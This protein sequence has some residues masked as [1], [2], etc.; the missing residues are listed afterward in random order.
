MRTVFIVSSVLVATSL[1]AACGDDGAVTDADVAVADSVAG[2]DV[3]DVTDDADVADADDTSVPEDTTPARPRANR[4]IG[5][6]SMGAAA[7]TIALERPGTFDFVGALGGYADTTYMMSQMLRLQL[8]GF[9]PLTDLA[10]RP[11]ALDDPDA[12]PPV[13]CGPGLTRSELEVPQD[14]DH[15]QYDDNGI[16]MTRE[17]YGSV[18][19]NFAEA[20]GNLAVPAAPSAP[21]WPAG[22]D[23]A[24]F[25]STG[26][27]ERCASPRPIDARYAF[28]AEYN[29]EGLYDVIPLCDIKR[30]S[31]PEM[32]PSWFDTAAPRNNPIPPLLAVDI[33]GN[34]RRDFGEPVML[35]P[36]ERFADVGVDGC[37]DAHEDGVGGCVAEAQELAPGDDPNGDRYHWLDNP[38]GTEANDGYELGEPFADLGLDG[39][40]SEVAG[41]ADQG[42]GNGV[43]DAVDSLDSLLDHDADTRIRTVDADALETMDFWLDAGIRDVL[44]AGVA[45]RNLVA[46]LRSRG[47]DVRVYRDFTSNPDALVPEMDREELIGQL[48]DLDLSAEAVGRDIYIEYGDPNASADEIEDGDGKHVGRGVD[49]LNRLASYLV[50]ALQRFPDPDYE[51]APLS[52]PASMVDTYFSA[53]LKARR[54]YT[55]GL[56]PGYDLPENADTRYPVVFFLHGLGQD[57]TDLSAAAVATS[58][59]MSEGF[60][61]KAI[62]VF[63][64]GG[65]CFVDQETG[66]RECACGDS[67][68]GVRTCVDPACTGAAEECEARD[69]PDGR[70]QRECAKGSL[71]ANM[72]ANRWGEPRDDLGYRQSV[73]DLVDYVD[74]RWRTRSGR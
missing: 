73:L 13:M 58:M 12:D 31:D 42:E 66:G 35:N 46:A 30:P 18:I 45:T 53:G 48:F 56:P 59:L 9:C 37:D 16:T 11:D 41:F 2:D 50:A 3:E 40:S 8:S 67:H 65:C 39:V 26:A 52:T 27:A 15:L 61:P 5:G 22:L 25:R 44:S 68:G 34:G 49:A 57:A 32:L 36:W 29:P 17:F 1:T 71:Y 38:D 64:D 24:W 69:I 55:L 62:F 20:Y 14:F 7:I 47:R 72:S 43:W 6:M 28:N 21:S 10:T 54:S 74:T 19:E 4:A 63:P 33:N 70:L 51:P 23:L 60:L